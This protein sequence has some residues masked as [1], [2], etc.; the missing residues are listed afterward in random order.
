MP[1]TSFFD[2]LNK[3]KNYFF[4]PNTTTAAN[5]TAQQKNNIVKN[6][7]K[8]IAE[9]TKKNNPVIS[10][11]DLKVVAT[12][13]GEALGE[14]ERGQHAVINSI[15]NRIKAGRGKDAFDIV[16]TPYQYDAFSVNNQ[17]Y[18]KARDYLRGD[19]TKLNSTEQ[20]KIGVI[21]DLYNKA[22]NNQLPDIVGG[23]TNYLNPTTTTDTG[24]K[25]YNKR[26]PQKD[27]AIG[28]HVFWDY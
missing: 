18:S 21:I 15:F 28:N 10:D 16:S 9:T 8:K 7:V 14:D 4:K 1:Q 26:N 27:V 2:Q 19:K 12:V 13:F 11:R 17:L 25:Y 22:K 6:Q 23:N 5:T 20:Q 24:K 3:W